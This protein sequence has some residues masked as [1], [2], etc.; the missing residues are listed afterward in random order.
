MITYYYFSTTFQER[1]IRE[2]ADYIFDIFLTVQSI[3]NESFREI[4]NLS[5]KRQ[6]PIDVIDNEQNR[7]LL[8]ERLLNSF[9]KE[10]K[11]YEENDNPT[12]DTILK[13][14]QNCTIKTQIKGKQVFMEFRIACSIPSSIEFVVRD[15]NWEYYYHK[16]LFKLF[17][18]AINPQYAYEIPWNFKRS[19]NYVDL[20]KNIYVVG[21][22]NYFSKELS[23]ND[24]IEI[25]NKNKELFND[26]I[27][28]SSI[29]EVFDEEN[30]EHIEKAKAIFNY[31][32]EKGILKN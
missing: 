5:L 3:D 27:I 29:D 12:I 22:L 8:A 30:M 17:I 25:E 10:L 23:L 11:E 9:K 20:P 24:I 18:N 16:N 26:G 4:N 2:Y 19:L 1:T 32:Q 13:I 28:I 6:I 14:S 7:M 31:F 15:T 21:W